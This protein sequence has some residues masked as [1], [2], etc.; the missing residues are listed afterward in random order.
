MSVYSITPVFG[1][2]VSFFFVVL[3]MSRNLNSEIN[4]RP[5]STSTVADHGAQIETRPNSLELVLADVAET[6]FF[7]FRTKVV[8]NV[9]N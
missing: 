2:T 6:T 1:A 9:S 5:R 8:L 3:V 4:Q 7:I